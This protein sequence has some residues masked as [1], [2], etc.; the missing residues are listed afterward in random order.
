[1]ALHIIID[2]SSTVFISMSKITQANNIVK[3]IIFSNQI[4]IFSC[5]SNYFSCFNKTLFNVF[6]LHLFN[7]S[8]STVRL[9]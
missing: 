6:D 9:A 5:F 8:K 4:N 7:N 1:M 2:Y 3:I